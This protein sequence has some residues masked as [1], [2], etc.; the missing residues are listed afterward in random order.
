MNR[1]IFY[2]ALPCFS[3]L[4][5]VVIRPDTLSLGTDTVSKLVA[6]AYKDAKSKADELISK[7]MTSVTGGMDE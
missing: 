1:A 4:V 3:Y 7:V 6:D 5:S 2:I